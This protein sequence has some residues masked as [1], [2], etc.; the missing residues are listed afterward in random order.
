MCLVWKADAALSASLPT[1]PATMAC[2]YPRCIALTLPVL[3]ILFR[4]TR[5]VAQCSPRRV[6]RFSHHSYS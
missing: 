3:R 1:L 6:C 5:A 2:L 4:S